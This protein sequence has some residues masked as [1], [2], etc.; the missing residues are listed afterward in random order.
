MS[1]TAY[2]RLAWDIL[3]EGSNGLERNSQF[4]KSLYDLGLTSQLGPFEIDHLASYS[5]VNNKGHIDGGAHLRLP[6]RW[7]RDPERTSADR[8]CHP[9]HWSAPVDSFRWHQVP[10]DPIVNCQFVPD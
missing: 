9:L 10:P 6:C 3:A 8:V 7:C 1:Q 5:T 2:E 4:S